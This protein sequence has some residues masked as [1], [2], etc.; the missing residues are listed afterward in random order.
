[1]IQLLI[2]IGVALVSSF[3]I[4]VL[5]VSFEQTAV[6]ARENKSVER[7]FSWLFLYPL[8]EMVYKF[9]E[10]LRK[11][12][13]AV[14]NFIISILVWSVIVTILYGL[15]EFIKWIFTH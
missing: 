10:R 12:F 13:G 8:F 15:Y 2:F 5:S 7:I 6:K 14:A 3:V 9:L 4:A 11:F 1:M